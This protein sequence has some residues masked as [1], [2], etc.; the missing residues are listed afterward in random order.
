[1]NTLIQE[2]N[3]SNNLIKFIEVGAGTPISNEFF[4]YP[5]ASKTVFDVHS[6][7]NNARSFYNIPEDI[8]MVSNNALLRIVW[9][10]GKHSDCKYVVM[11]TFQIPSN[12]K[13]IPHGWIG[14]LSAD[15]FITY[16]ITLPN[17]LT[18]EECISEIGRIGVNLIHSEIFD[19]PFE[20]YQNLFIDN[21][22]VFNGTEF[23]YGHHY[24]SVLSQ[25]C[26]E[27]ILIVKDG[28][29]VR[30]EEEY[31][32]VGPILVFKGSFNPIHDGHLEICNRTI[33]NYG[34]KPLFLISTKTYQ[35]GMVDLENLKVR[36]KKINDCGYNVGIM[37]NGFFWD[38]LKFLQDRTFGKT[39]IIACCGLDTIDRLV[40]CYKNYDLSA[41]EFRKLGQTHD[42]APNKFMENMFRDFKFAVYDRKMG[43]RESL[44]Y[45][46]LNIDF[47]E[48]EMDISSSEI[49]NRK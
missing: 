12:N 15:K 1:M 31:R 11:N 35:K 10:L 37:N 25:T 4:K 38:N 29:F 45:A 14:I 47:H 43:D 46:N 8:R 5:N 21:C 36:V 17:N 6:P 44:S 32:D 7:Y 13:V 20:S 27:S 34:G 24:D 9:S 22:Y 33:Q 30:F 49:R 41:K 2:I 19:I 18:R 40:K 23:T 3:N 16:H 42:I 26:E 28:Q 39:D 48:F